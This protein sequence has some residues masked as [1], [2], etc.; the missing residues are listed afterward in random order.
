ML[1]DNNPLSH[2][3]RRK[4]ITCNV[5]PIKTGFVRQ[6]GETHLQEILMD[7]SFISEVDLTAT[8]NICFHN[9]AS[10][11]LT[12]TTNMFS[13]MRGKFSA[14]LFLLQKIGDISC[15]DSQPGFI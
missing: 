10:S 13:L 1:N 3:D 9:S 14:K 2:C 7:E 4:H 8:L 11:C 12:A 6:H 15:T 5:C